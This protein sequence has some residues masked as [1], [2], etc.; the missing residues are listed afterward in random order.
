MYVRVQCAKECDGCPGVVAGVHV[1]CVV[2]VACCRTRSGSLVLVRVTCCLTCCVVR[3]SGGRYVGDVSPGCLGRVGVL[4]LVVE[5]GESRVVVFDEV[6]GAALAVC[7]AV[8]QL[9][10]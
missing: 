5:F 6:G 3:S 4:V 7:V 1:V 9:S 2:H 8:R 10:A